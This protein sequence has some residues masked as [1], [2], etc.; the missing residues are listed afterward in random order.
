MAP[1][2]SKVGT[3]IKYR[4]PSYRRAR[5]AWATRVAS[6]GVACHLCGQPI[7]GAFDLDHVRGGGRGGATLHPAHQSCNRSEGGAWRGKRR[8]AWGSSG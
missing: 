2:S 1:R 3:R 8:L 6:G 7:V 4:D 5:S